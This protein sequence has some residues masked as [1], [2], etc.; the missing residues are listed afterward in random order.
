MSLFILKV[1]Q[2]TLT[3]SNKG[4]ELLPPS[5]PAVCSRVP[6]GHLLFFSSLFYGLLCSMLTSR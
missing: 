6:L 2:T 3:L 1:T 5:A 4:S